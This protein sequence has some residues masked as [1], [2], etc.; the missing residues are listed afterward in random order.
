[1]RQESEQFG[2][3]GGGGQHG[4]RGGLTEQS[5]SEGRS[6]EPAITPA[7]PDY[8][9]APPLC[10]PRR[11]EAEQVEGSLLQQGGG[12]GDYE[13]LQDGRLVLEVGCQFAT[14]EE[15]ISKL[16]DWSYQN[17]ISIVK[18]SRLKEKFV[19][20]KFQGAVRIFRCPHGIERKS[21][22]K[23]IRC[24]QSVNYTGCKF[25]IRIT[26]KEDKSWRIT[27]MNSEHYG[28]ETTQQ[29]FFI[30]QNNRKLTPEDRQFVIDMMQGNASNP[31]MAA[32]LSQRTGRI[33]SYQDVANLV[34]RIS[35]EEVVDPLEKKRKLLESEQKLPYSPR[36][37]HF[38]IQV[39]SAVCVSFA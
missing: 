36:M 18:A 10:S 9:Y 12:R 31:N 13:S 38:M 15:A 33:Y 3:G 25:C 11:P 29:N 35:D 8:R 26:E 30:H 2:G 28:H 22:S 1:M 21:K 37:N 23:G 27:S 4:G 24:K 16:E 19:N 17:K 34:K 39:I 5:V 20:G 6:I 7:P 14:E 32:A